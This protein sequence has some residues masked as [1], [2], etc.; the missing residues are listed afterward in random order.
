VSR[1]ASGV[2]PPPAPGRPVLHE[3][4]AAL[5]RGCLYCTSP[6]PSWS[7]P[8]PPSVAPHPRAVADLKG[9]GR[10]RPA[11][12][13][14]PGAR[15]PI[16]H[17][18]AQHIITLRL[19]AE[20]FD[21]DVRTVS[22]HW[23]NVYSS[24]EPAR[25]ATVRKLRTARPED[26][27]PVTR[28]IDRYV[29]HAIISVG[30]LDLGDGYQAECIGIWLPGRATVGTW[31]TQEI[32]GRNASK[33]LAKARKDVQCSPEWGMEMIASRLQQN[34]T[35]AIICSG[36]YRGR[37]FLR[38][39]CVL[40]QTAA[41]RPSSFKAKVRPQ[42]RSQSPIR[43]AGHPAPP[44]RPVT[45]HHRH[46]RSPS[47]TVAAG[48]PAPPSRPVTLDHRHGQPPCTAVG[49]EQ[50]QRAPSFSHPQPGHMPSTAA[51]TR[52]PSGQSPGGKDERV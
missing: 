35:A 13:G 49:A 5:A 44:S 25:E 52:L 39:D 2:R 30:H 15:Q 31:E 24:A 12:R 41:V 50:S 1:P 38:E 11:N 22:E 32:L 7:T 18:T 42:G 34:L 17:P 23:G 21:V 28:S 51:P 3:G 46:G 6:G 27:R 4:G 45:Q 36:T 8:D 43:A 40:P 19:M 14:P 16:R 37:T 47:T 48:H 26:S 9:P 29:L 10:A 33:V 20:L